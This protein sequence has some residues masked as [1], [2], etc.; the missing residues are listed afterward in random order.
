MLVPAFVI[1]RF[2][3]FTYW[4]AK[5]PN[6]LIFYVIRGQTFQFLFPVTINWAYTKLEC[7]SSDSVNDNTEVKFPSSVSIYGISVLSFCIWQTYKFYNIQTKSVTQSNWK[8][9]TDTCSKRQFVV[10]VFY[11]L[12]CIKK[13]L[14]KQNGACAKNRKKE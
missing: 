11:I 1:C 3:W 9:L 5:N 12:L 2:A 4:N 6:H 13:S 10:L 7:L 14:I 8:C